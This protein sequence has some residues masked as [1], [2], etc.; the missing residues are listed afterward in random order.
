METKDHFEVIFARTYPD[1]TK[2]LVGKIGN[3]TFNEIRV[4][5]YLRMGYSNK[6]ICSQLDISAQTISNLR[7]GLRKKMGLSR[8]QDLTGAIICL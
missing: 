4:C 7:S 6:K 2:K 8:G 5:M 3:L 1:F